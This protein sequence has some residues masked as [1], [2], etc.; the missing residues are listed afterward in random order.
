MATSSFYRD[1]APNQQPTFEWYRPTLEQ[2]L[3][4]KPDEMIEHILNGGLASRKIE[5]KKTDPETLTN[6]LDQS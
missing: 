3:Q 5:V 1:I 6:T 2:V 4:L